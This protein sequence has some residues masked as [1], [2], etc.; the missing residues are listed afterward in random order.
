MRNR[1]YL[2]AA[3]IPRL[4]IGFLLAVLAGVVRGLHAAE[5][6]PA[7]AGAT[8]L[9][10]EQFLPLSW[11][12]AHASAASQAQVA[13]VP[14]VFAGR[15]HTASLLPEPVVRCAGGAQCWMLRAVDHEQEPV[16]CTHRLQF[17]KSD[18]NTL[19]GLKKCSCSG[20][21]DSRP[22]ASAPGHG[23]SVSTSVSSLTAQPHAS[24]Y[25]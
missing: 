16:H 9:C 18:L 22:M 12:V 21:R 2:G 19:P 5:Q 20:L 1:R 23:L 13:L 3:A 4:L 8:L 11:Q 14:V 10:V 6:L 24:S 25:Y 7:S 17:R 15:P